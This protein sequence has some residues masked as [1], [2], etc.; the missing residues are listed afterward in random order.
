L[1]IA[2]AADR[3]TR[4]NLF[5]LA[6]AES[7]SGKS[8]VFRRIAEPIVEHQHQSHE[9]FCEKTAPQLASEI[10]L[11]TREIKRLETKAAKENT[12]PTVRQSLRRTGLARR[13]DIP[14]RAVWPGRP[15]P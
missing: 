7:G 12:D 9:A 1:E 13:L 5:V 2:S 3:V 4:A 15:H 6:D 14:C 8:Q 10:G 11:L